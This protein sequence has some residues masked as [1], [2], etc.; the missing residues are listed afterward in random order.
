M[1]LVLGV[2]GSPT[3][4]PTLYKYTELGWVLKTHQNREDT[5]IALKKQTTKKTVSCE[6]LPQDWCLKW[7]AGGPWKPTYG[8]PHGQILHS[9]ALSKW[10]PT[11]SRQHQK[12]WLLLSGWGVGDERGKKGSGIQRRDHLT[13]RTALMNQHRR[14]QYR[15]CLCPSPKYR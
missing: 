12:T 5:A 13:P 4:P 6:H 15:A 1:F 3:L 10:S 8:K 7:D 9:S 11:P 14:F 2:L